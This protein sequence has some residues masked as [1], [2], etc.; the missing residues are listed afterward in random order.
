MLADAPDLQAKTVFEYLLTQ[1]PGRYVPGPL[2]PLQRRVKHWRAVSGP[3]REVFFPQRHV[4]GEAFQKDFTH[5][6][7]LYITTHSEALARL[8][9]H[10]VLPASNGQWATVCRSEPMA[11]L[12]DGVQN[13]VFKLGC[14]APYHQTDNSTAPTHDLRT[15]KR[16]FNKD[17]A[18]FI[19]HLGMTPRTTGVGKK[20]QNSD[21]E[22]ANGVLNRRITQHLLVRGCRDF[23]SVVTYQSWLHGVLEAANVLRQEA[24]DRELGAMR[25]VRVK[26]LLSY[27]VQ[28]LELSA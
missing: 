19:A 1:R 22:S 11:A 4:L 14:A 9:C 16:V 15:G 6:N 23:S 7:K 28:D 8:L 18:D 13:A 20:E 17:Y 2:R 24:I 26:R 25:P 5:F 3:P 10:V 21:V 27:I 12:R